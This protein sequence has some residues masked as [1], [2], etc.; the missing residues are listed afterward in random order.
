MEDS[1]YAL[2]LNETFECSGRSP[3]MVLSGNL[4]QSESLRIL[5]L[6]LCH[7]NVRR[8][9]CAKK[10]LHVRFGKIERYATRIKSTRSYLS[11]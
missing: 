2:T 3:V 9:G 6:K 5:L 8:F 10:F 4:I 11:S 1:A 7:K